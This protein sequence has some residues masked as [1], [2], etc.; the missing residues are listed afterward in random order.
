MLLNCN[1][2]NYHTDE[3]GNI[4][5]DIPLGTSPA[6]AYIRTNIKLRTEIDKV[7]SHIDGVSTSLSDMQSQL[8]SADSNILEEID[9]QIATVN[10]NIDTHSQNINDRIDL[11]IT[12]VSD[13]ILAEKTTL[14]SRIDTIV[15]NSTASEGNTELIDIRTDFQG[16]VYQTAGTSVREQVETLDN[17]LSELQDKLGGNHSARLRWELGGIDNEGEPQSSQTRLRTTDYIRLPEK[18]AF[19]H[20]PENFTVAIVG[21]DSSKHYVNKIIGISTDYTLNENQNFDY[22][23]VVMYF[24]NSQIITPTDGYESG[25]FL[26]VDEDEHYASASTLESEIERIK[27]TYLFEMNYQYIPPL[28]TTQGY[29]NSQG[30]I[31]YQNPNYYLT[32]YFDV[33]DC[34]AVNTF[35]II[36]SGVYGAWYDESKTL[37]STF[38]ENSQFNAV[39]EKPS[40]TV[41]YCRMTVHASVV[42]N[43]MIFKGYV[44]KK[45]TSP[46]EQFDN[47]LIPIKKNEIV[48]PDTIYKASDKEC[49]IYHDNIC[50][51]LPSTNGMFIGTNYGT[52]IGS[53][54]CDYERF[55]RT[56]SNATVYARVINA[57]LDVTAE[58][59]F[60]IVNVPA[61]NL[62]QSVKIMAIGDSLTDMG[63]HLWQIHDSL[64]TYGCTPLWIGTNK[65]TH[66][67][68]TVDNQTYTINREALSGGRLEQFVTNTPYNPFWNSSQNKNNVSSYLSDNHL[69][70]PD[71]LIVQFTLNDIVKY[72]ARDYTPFIDNLKTLYNMFKVVNNDIKLIFSVEP[73]GCQLKNGDNTEMTSSA[74]LSLAKALIGEFT[75]NENYPN[76]YICPS[77]AFVDRLY[78][79][80]K[81]EVSFAYFSEKETVAYDAIHP[82]TGGGKQLGDAILGMLLALLK[83]F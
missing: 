7:Q 13:R 74:V 46:Y 44:P 40:N 66:A 8:E 69:E 83:G 25:I 64:T 73:C 78:G 77:Y 71:Y 35:N 56:G 22:V 12:N 42:E 60:S 31:L 50:H 67:D 11:E 57:D 37:I 54:N 58:K 23:K 49:N 30:V 52:T 3:N 16:R 81:K 26:T 75:D 4:H 79:Y 15:A 20:C 2:N 61:E 62:P 53:N 41:K 29:L 28:D 5:R 33:S 47:S 43:Y 70:T 80:N 32:D 45:W 18:T 21:Y 24:S 65:N 76:I 17:A 38:A 6:D 10:E 48:L 63:Y 72:P 19:L 34:E 39:Y 68:I 9:N 36:G 1:P 14:S 59:K 27:N 51:T 55:F 82:N